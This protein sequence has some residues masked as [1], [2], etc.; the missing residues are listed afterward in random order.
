MVVMTMGSVEWFLR[1]GLFSCGDPGDRL[2]MILLS[3]IVYGMAFDFFN[4]SG[5]LFVEQQSD[6][7]IRASA[8]RLFMV[9][10]NG[11]VAV[12]GSLASGFLI[13]HFFT[14]ADGSKDGHGI[15]VTFALYALAM[16]IRTPERLAG[17]E[18]VC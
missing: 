16:A 2:L 14:A 1:C 11:V 9:M 10:T 13:E 12:F 7:R 6:S 18:S 5:S 3:C 8:Q 4:I 15:G 17:Q